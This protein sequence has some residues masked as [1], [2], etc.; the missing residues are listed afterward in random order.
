MLCL[1]YSI[2]IFTLFNIFREAPRWSKIAGGILFP[3]RFSSTW[4]ALGGYALIL[5]KKAAP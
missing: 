5:P 2:A 3:A 4:N 1:Y